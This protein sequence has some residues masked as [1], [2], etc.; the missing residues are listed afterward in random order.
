MESAIENLA[1]HLEAD[2]NEFTKNHLIKLEG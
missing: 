1:N 2:T